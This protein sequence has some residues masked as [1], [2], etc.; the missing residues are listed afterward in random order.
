MATKQGGSNCRRRS[1]KANHKARYQAYRS[2]NRRVKNKLKRLIRHLLKFPGDDIAA[3]AE[4]RY[5]NLRG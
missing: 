2:S 1:A 3:R 5:R 4:D